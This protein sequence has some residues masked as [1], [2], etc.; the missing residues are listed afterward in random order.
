MLSAMLGSKYRGRRKGVAIRAGSVRQARFEA[1]LSLAQVAAGQ[2]SRTAVHHIENDR[3]KPSLETLRLIA[4]QTG[5]PIEYFLLAPHGQ[6]EL[7]EPH[8][9]IVQLE[10]MIAAREFQAVLLLGP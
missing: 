8:Q 4:R 5:K 10:R 6:P 1:R 7:N 9:E 3:V 2:V